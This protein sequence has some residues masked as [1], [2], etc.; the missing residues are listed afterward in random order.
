MPARRPHFLSPL[1]TAA[2]LANLQARG[3]SRGSISSQRPMQGAP[4]FAAAWKDADALLGRPLPVAAELLQLRPMPG[5]SS[6]AFW[7]PDLPDAI[8]AG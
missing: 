6:Q 2:L 7:I 3:F 4:N 5:V 1:V 8:E